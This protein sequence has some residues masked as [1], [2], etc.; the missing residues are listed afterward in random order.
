[1]PKT[2]K[3]TGPNTN[4]LALVKKKCTQKNLTL[5]RQPQLIRTV[6]M[7]VLDTMYNCNMQ[8]N[9]FRT[10]VI[11]AWHCQ[12]VAILSNSVRTYVRSSADFRRRKLVSK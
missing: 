2:H 1:M 8:Y 11:I 6:L 12:T 9:T 3:K 4:K 7:S 10:V 5:N